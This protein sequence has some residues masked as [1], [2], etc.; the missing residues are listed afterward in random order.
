MGEVHRID[1]HDG[2]CDP[3]KSHVADPWDEAGIFS[4]IDPI[5]FS[6]SW[7]GTYSSPMDP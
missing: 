2:N 5:N 1:A 7:I 4:H 3:M 6:H